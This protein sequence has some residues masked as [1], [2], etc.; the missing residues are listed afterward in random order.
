VFVTGY[1]QV[2]DPRT[3]AQGLV[4]EVVALDVAANHWNREL[5]DEGVKF[6]LY[7]WLLLGV[8]LG[9]I[10]LRA[11]RSARDALIDKLSHA[12]EQSQSG[13]LIVSPDGRIEFVNRGL[14]EQVGCSAPDLVSRHCRDLP[15]GKFPRELVQSMLKRLAVGESWQGEWFNTRKDGSQYPA[16]AL[17]TPV[18]GR[19]REHLG[20]IAVV[21]DLTEHQEHEQELRLAKDRAERADHAKGQ[22]LATMSHEVRTP[23]NGIVGFTN[24]LLDTP[25]SIEQ[26]EYVQTIRSS[27][28][29]LVQL[30]G[31]ILDFS[32]IES[33]TLQL[34]ASLCDV[35]G[36]VEEVLDIFAA[37]AAEKGIELL[38][39]VETDV[40][41]QVL[42]DTG[43]LRQV[44]TNLVG[45]GVKFTSTGHV[46]VN[47][48]VLT[49]KGA[50]MAPFDPSSPAGQLVAEFEDGGLALEFSVRDTGMGIA[51]EDRAKLFQPFTQLDASTVRRYGGA[52][53][54]LA[55][56][57]NVVRMMGGDIWLES[58]VGSGSCFTFNVRARCAPPS[59]MALV[60]PAD[61]SGCRIAL[62]C[63]HRRLHE[64]LTHVLQLNGA[65]VKEA[66]LGTLDLTTVD[67]V[68]VN[69]TESLIPELD[70][71][72]R[73]PG[74]SPERALGLVA[75]NATTLDRQFLRPHFRML[76]NKPVHHR[77]LT[78]LLSRTFSK[79]RARS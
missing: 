75:V 50:S 22:F 45:N 4:R 58:Q 32:R 3:T 23:L 36:A 78:D 5:L 46:E 11:R 57:R 39:S 21:T 74:W 25:L 67:F 65:M 18:H 64:E 54:G 30:T 15:Q 73:S 47:V 60:P 29:A 6:A 26:R 51:P 70:G 12:V 1:A 79:A 49:G 40:P 9:L 31:D 48:R 33:G 8:P 59:E 2:G 27:G 20:Y 41:S 62:V 13:M 61:L 77:S 53:L 68:L 28:E 63:E 72:A 34:D 24:L 56:S 66:T 10:T 55:I 19:K 38:H 76:L 16:Q 71:Q 52:G 14:C 43:R 7:A 35:R 42:L 37:R 17:V 69:C 44:L